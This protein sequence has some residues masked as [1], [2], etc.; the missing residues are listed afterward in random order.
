[1]QTRHSI[2]DLFSTFLQFEADRPRGW[3]AD[4]KLYR[5]AQQH[6]AQAVEEKSSERFWSIYWHKRWQTEQRV[7]NAAQADPKQ[8]D[9]KQRSL[10]LGHLSAYLQEPCYW[11][12]QKVMP[13]LPSSQ[14]KM[15]DFFQVAIADVPKILRGCDPNQPASLKTYASSAFSNIIRD[16]LRQRREIDFCNDWGLLLKLSRKRLTEVLQSE[17]LDPATIERY[18]L[19]WTCLEAVYLPSKKPGLRQ[20]EPP[21]AETWITIGDRYNRLRH[22]EL[23]DPGEAHKATTLERWLVYCAHRVRA[24]LYPAVKSLNTVN[25]EQDYGEWQDN[26]ADSAHDSVLADLIAREELQERQDQY[27]QVSAVLTEAIDALDP[28]AQTLLQLYYQQQLTQQ[29]IAKQLNIQQYTVSRKLAKAR[30]TLLL[31]F[32]RWSQ[33]ALHIAPDSNV[34]KNIS[35][36]LE[37]WLHGHYGHET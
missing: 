22:Q 28:T 25:T 19:A 24:T 1:M 18:V 13:R 5:S 32:S 17:G 4:A 12:V 7:S 27:G 2:P 16:F 8:A 36:I 20:T 34:I 14:Y 37:E 6:L 31:K 10:S 11:A 23:S 21:D 33:E 9:S 15:S 35:P 30:E 29:E 26:L 3:V